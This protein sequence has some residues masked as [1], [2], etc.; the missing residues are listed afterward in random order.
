MRDAMNIAK[1]CGRE[2]ILKEYD[3]KF[4]DFFEQAVTTYKLL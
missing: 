4:K 1:R 2:D 3:A